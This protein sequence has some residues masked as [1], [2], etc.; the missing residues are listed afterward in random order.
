MEFLSSSLDNKLKG[1]IAGFQS[2]C[3]NNTIVIRNKECIVLQVN[4][5]GANVLVQRAVPSYE[6]DV[7]KLNAADP[8]IINK[9]VDVLYGRT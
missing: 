4:I 7:H 2:T 8:Q 9:I 1:E 6:S 5:D 3:A